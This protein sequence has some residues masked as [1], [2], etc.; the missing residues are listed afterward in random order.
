MG[1][2]PDGPLLVGWRLGLASMGLFLGPV[3]LAILGA[4]WSGRSH[5]ARFLGAITGLGIGMAGSVAVAKLLR[6]DKKA[7]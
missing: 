3:V 5:E 4:M 6:R 7:P 1:G 2:E